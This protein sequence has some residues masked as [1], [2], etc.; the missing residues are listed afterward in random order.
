MGLL[1]FSS[2]GGSLLLS[3]VWFGV[4][5]PQTRSSYYLFF[6]YLYYYLYWSSRMVEESRGV[7][8]RM[9]EESRGVCLPE[10]SWKTP[11][12]HSDLWIRL[13]VESL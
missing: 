5:Y 6:Y 8:S 9:V 2:K 11:Q 7:S 1:R 13:T 10:W 12:N 4:I 3:G